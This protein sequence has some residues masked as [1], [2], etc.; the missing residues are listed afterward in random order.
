MFEIM[1]LKSTNGTFANKEKLTPNKSYIF[2]SNTSISLGVEFPIDLTKILKGIQ[3]IKTP[4]N[5]KPQQTVP[6]NAPLSIEE[7]KSFKELESIWNEFMERQHNIGS[8]SNNWTIGGAAIGA[9]ASIFLGPAGILVATGSG[10]MGRYLGMQK[11]KEIKTD[12]NYEN[13]FLVT[14][15]CPRCKESFQKRPWVT[16]RECFKCKVKFREL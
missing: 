13:I 12:L 15:S 7:S 9:V 6:L 10:L 2:P 4:T 5:E 8:V 16:I 14:Y 1:D 11:A 3:I